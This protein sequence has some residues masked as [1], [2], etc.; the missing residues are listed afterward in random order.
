[1]IAFLFRVRG[2][3]FILH[4]KGTVSDF[5]DIVEDLPLMSG[6]QHSLIHLLCIHCFLQYLF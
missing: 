4:I 5:Q 3:H 1:M 6:K 2:M